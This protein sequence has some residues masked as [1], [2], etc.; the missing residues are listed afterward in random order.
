MIF[1]KIGLG[2]LWRLRW[3][4]KRKK[5]GTADS[6]CRDPSRQE[7]NQGVCGYLDVITC[8]FLSSPRPSPKERE[9]NRRGF[10]GTLSFVLLLVNKGLKN[11]I[12][13]YSIVSRPRIN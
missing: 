8:L 2:W 5:I 1:F 6:V 7:Q 12:A 10:S 13:R 4:G 9:T 3:V 11:V